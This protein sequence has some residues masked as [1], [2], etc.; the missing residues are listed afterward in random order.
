MMRQNFNDFYNENYKIAYNR[1]R[2]KIKNSEDAKDI[3]AD[4]FFHICQHYDH[5]QNPIHYL[6]SALSNQIKQYFHKKNRKIPLDELI[7]NDTVVQ[8]L[9]SNLSL[10]DELIQKAIKVFNEVMAESN[11][12]TREIFSLMIIGDASHDYIQLSFGINK[13]KYNKIIQTTLNKIKEKLQT[14]E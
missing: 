7:D 12:L 10:S 5:I 1:V 6:N 3:T 8:Y 9:D 2:N 11:E 13:N 4:V 14:N